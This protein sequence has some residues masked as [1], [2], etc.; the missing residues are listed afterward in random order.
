M[1]TP[2]SSSSADTGSAAPS[3]SSPTLPS[4]SSD[5][6]T[7]S[8]SSTSTTDPGSSS[9]SAP[10]SASSVPSSSSSTPTSSSSTSTSSTPT[11]TPTPTSAPSSVVTFESL[12]RSTDATGGVVTVTQTRTS[13]NAAATASGVVGDRQAT[14]GFLQNKGAVA[15]VFTIV[16][17]V[18]AGLLFALVT[19]AL[20]RRRAKRFDREIA[21]EAK[22]APA[23]VFMDDDD[24]Y[25]GGYSGAYAGGGGGGYSDGAGYGAQQHQADPYAASHGPSSEG[26]P[27]SDAVHSG[28]GTPSNYMYPSGYSDLGFSEVSSHGTYAQPPME[29]YNAGGGGYGGYGG[30]GVGAPGA[31]EM[32]GYAPHVGQD[33]HAQAQGG[34][35]GQD[36]HA[37]GGQGGGYVY[38]GDE[39]Q[40]VVQGGYPPTATTAHS[41]GSD[42]LGR[43]KSGARSLVDSYNATPSEGGSGKGTPG[44]Q[45]QYADGYVSQYQTH[46]VEDDGAYGGM[47]SH[48]GHV[49]GLEDEESDG[50]GDG[51]RVLKVANN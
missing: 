6:S 50:E 42:G 33:W 46:V 40:H 41:S 44:T 11:P 28:G 51:R 20:R 10:P 12:S 8:P 3:S 19:N 15:A 38:P 43:S 22:R 21:E 31:Y 49:G 16:G 7:S 14:K 37:Q 30:A 18:A 36:W 5:S 2:E 39:N 13:T 29:A 25:A 24:D 23:P 27:A 9:S 34:Q 4:S 26:Y 17:L 47:E 1:A 45:P 35:V 48:H 32:T